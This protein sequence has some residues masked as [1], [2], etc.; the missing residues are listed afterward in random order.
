[1]IA[2][3]AKARQA[4][5]GPKTGRGKKRT[6]GANLAPAVKGKTRDKVAKRKPREVRLE[7]F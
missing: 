5:A 4:A 3:E 7:G 6:G 2:A 1:M